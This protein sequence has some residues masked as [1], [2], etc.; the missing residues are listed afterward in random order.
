MGIYGDAPMK[1]AQHADRFSTAVIFK[2][3]SNFI[4]STTGDEAAMTKVE[5]QRLKAVSD[6]YEPVGSC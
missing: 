2:W 5:A 1:S 6:A 3:H 4:S